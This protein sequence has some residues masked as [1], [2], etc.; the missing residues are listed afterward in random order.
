MIL[1][2]RKRDTNKETTQLTRSNQLSV[3]PNCRNISNDSRFKRFQSVSSREEALPLRDAV[4]THQKFS[5]W[6]LRTGVKAEISSNPIRLIN[7][8]FSGEFAESFSAMGDSA[9]RNAI[10]A[11][12]AG[13]NE[14]FW[15]NIQKALATLSKDDDCNKSF[16]KDNEHLVNTGF[17]PQNTEQHSWE[18]L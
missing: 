10:N 16:F 8:L 13:N 18:K 11:N 15:I 12:E 1:S 7:I 4:D 9:K 14:G 17:N 3:K 6:P 5:W 2:M